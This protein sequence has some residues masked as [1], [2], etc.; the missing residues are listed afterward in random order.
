ME[1]LM[2]CSSTTCSLGLL[3]MIL[4]CLLAEVDPYSISGDKDVWAEGEVLNQQ[5]LAKAGCCFEI[6]YGAMNKPCCLK[7]KSNVLRSNCKSDGP[8]RLGGAKGFTLGG[9]PE[10][11][12]AAK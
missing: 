3:F 7:T 9:C 5:E 10:T 12:A 4:P 2:K 8:K 11:A 1:A 6:G